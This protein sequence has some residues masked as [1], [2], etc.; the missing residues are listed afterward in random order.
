MKELDW[1]I[2][3]L[4][5]LLSKKKELLFVNIWRP[6]NVAFKENKNQSFET[7]Q[8]FLY[9]YGVKIAVGLVKQPTLPWSENDRFD[10]HLIFQFFS[11]KSTVLTATLSI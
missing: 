9:N 2:L 4:M 6:K 3:G 1:E 11:L 5:R 8:I 7:Q 10:F